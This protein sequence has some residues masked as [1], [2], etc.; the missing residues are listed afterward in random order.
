MRFAVFLGED[1]ISAGTVSLKDL[2][3]GEQRALS[4]EEAAGKILAQMAEDRKG[5][6]LKSEV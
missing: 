3:T 5:T 4:Q 2:S 6:I 1:E